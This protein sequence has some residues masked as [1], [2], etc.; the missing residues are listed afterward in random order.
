[1]TTQHIV[2]AEFD[3]GHYAPRFILD[4][5]DQALA[6]SARLNQAATSAYSMDSLPENRRGPMHEILRAAA[7]EVLQMF[8]PAG[9][10]TVRYVVKEVR[11]FDE[12]AE[13]PPSNPA[14][15]LFRTIRDFGAVPNPP[16]P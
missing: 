8:D 5:L 11:S 15:A 9:V 4:D 14:V 6:L 2:I 3:D 7:M 1:M 13:A 10:P 12:P 16:P